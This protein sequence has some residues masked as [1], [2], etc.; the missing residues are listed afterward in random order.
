MQPSTAR[1][2][3]PCAME[4]PALSLVPQEG[5]RTPGP[6][7]GECAARPPRPDGAQDARLLLCFYVAAWGVGPLAGLILEAISC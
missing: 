7:A 3:P 5:M 1:E 2:S 4:L 6:R